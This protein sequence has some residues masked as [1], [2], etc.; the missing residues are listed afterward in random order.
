LGLKVCFVEEQ[1]AFATSF[2]NTVQPTEAVSY[3]QGISFL[4]LFFCFY[5]CFQAVFIFLIQWITHENA[6]LLTVICNAFDGDT[7]YF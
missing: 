4:I 2:C 5:S 1:T 6:I 3:A 7:Q